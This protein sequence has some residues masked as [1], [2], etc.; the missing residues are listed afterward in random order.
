MNTSN[1]FNKVT[2]KKCFRIA[3]VIK[4]YFTSILLFSLYYKEFVKFEGTI[5]TR[6]PGFP[7]IEPF[8]TKIF[9]LEFI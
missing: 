5:L 6:L 9:S 8:I 3:F 4:N 1:K 2:S 7:G